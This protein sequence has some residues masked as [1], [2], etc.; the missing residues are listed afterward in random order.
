MQYCQNK[1]VIR[2]KGNNN[3]VQG[4]AHD[5]AKTGIFRFLTYKFY[6]GPFRFLADAFQEHKAYKVQKKST[7]QD[8]NTY[9]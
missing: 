5:K 4:N 3:N 7:H 8:H 1:L 9:N 6:Q 2:S